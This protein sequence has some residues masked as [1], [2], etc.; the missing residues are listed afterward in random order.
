M[1]ALKDVISPSRM[2][3]GVVSFDIG[4]DL[5]DPK[6][7]VA[8]EVFEDRFCTRASSGAS[9][10]RQGAGGPGAAACP[11][12]AGNDLQRLV[13]GAVGRLAG[14]GAIE[15]AA[16]WRALKCSRAPG[17]KRRRPFAVSGARRSASRIR[18]GDRHGQQRSG[19]L[20]SAVDYPERTLPLFEAHAHG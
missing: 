17:P 4:R 15:L 6:V 9:R 18:S 5:T 19:R 3:E 1:S 13:V 11:C 2:L 16:S 14:S 8:T 12:S 7:F 20:A 10:G